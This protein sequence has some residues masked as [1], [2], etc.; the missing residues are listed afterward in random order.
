[1]IN[2][3][4]QRLGQLIQPARIQQLAKKHGWC[5]RRAKISG[6]EFFYS[7][8][9]G[10][11]SAL[12]LTLNAQASSLS[13]T[14]TRQ[15]VDQ[16]YN[17]A[18]VEFFKAVFEEALASALEAQ[19][20]SAMAQVLHQ[21]FGAIRLFDSTQCPCSEALAKIFPGCGGG[22]SDAGLKVLLS[23]DYGR[24]QLQ[25][26]AVLAAKRSDQGLADTVAQQV[27]RGELGLWD[28]GFYKAHSLRK[29][30]ARGG[31]F[32]LPWSRSVS[33]WQTDAAGQPT[34]P[35]DMAAYLKASSEACVDWPA[36]QLGQTQDSRLGP[37]RLVAYRLTQDKANRRRAQLREKCRT[38]GRQ[39]TEQALELAGWLILMTNAPALLLPTAALGYLYR[40]RWQ[41]ELIFRQWKSVLRLDVIP[42]R[43]A[44]RVQC[45]VWARLVAALLTSVWHQHA[46]AACLE[47][48]Q[49][50]ISFSKLAKLLQQHGQ[51][52][53]QTL[54][55][56]RAHIESV[57]RT[58]WKKLLK[59]ARKEHQPSR[60]TTWQNLC[61]H[62]LDVPLVCAAEPTTP[63]S[64]P[65]R[66]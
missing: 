49:R 41:V 19:T 44:C 61:S 26:L 18:A 3:L 6:F 24:S 32:L 47:L 36:V 39:P 10:Q 65:Q 57:F 55:A 56:N 50:E 35:I 7:G 21:R 15:A 9:L 22:G 14:V 45:E 52:V 59:L 5:K 53:V 48:H 43:N 16:R 8:A 34:A 37:V 38:Y 13:Q 31:Y 42:S 17:P 2:T 25:P 20:D 30:A 60:P 23:Y 66:Q 54:F 27:G 1:M 51:L 62:W 63:K 40:V 33:V 4:L 29:L 28:K 64:A 46:N 12:E 58:I 11:A